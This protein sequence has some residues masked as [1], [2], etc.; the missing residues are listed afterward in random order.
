MAAFTLDEIITATGG[1]LLQG[2][3]EGSVSGI[4][5][6]SRKIQPGELFVAIQG[7]NFDGHDFI[8]AAVAAGAGAVLASKPVTVASEVAAVRVAD[9]L[10]A[11]GAIA[12]W[13]RRRFSIPVI[14]IT[15]SNGKTTTKDLVASVLAQ[16]YPVIKTEG[17]FNNEIGLP[18]TLL[19]FNIDFRAAVVEMGM[20][21][22]GQIRRLAGIAEPNIAIVTNVGLTHLELL[23]T[24]ENIARAKAELIESLPDD[25]LAVL[26]GDDPLVRSMRDKFNGRTILYGIEGP[27]LDYRAADIKIRDNGSIF[28]IYARGEII[29]AQL[30][31]PG[32]HNVLNALASVA[33]GREL[34]VS[35]DAIRKGLAAPDLTGK[36]LN[37][38][39]RNGL[40]IIDD[41]Y[42][43]SPTSARAALDV[44]AAT[45]EGRRKLAVLA[46]MLEL[47]PQA[48]AIHREIGEYAA[49]NGI[50]RLLAYGDLAREYV[51]GFNRISKGH[52][53]YF[54]AKLSLI[55]ELRSVIQ[56]GDVLLVKGSRG[57]KMEDIVAAISKLEVESSWN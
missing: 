28:K 14:G 4:A 50:D 12:R 21:G 43:A 44:L 6:D 18:L 24:Q 41:T 1:S 31:V 5:I 52:G 23:G 17:N 32:R 34:G 15:G 22:L 26:N 39:R 55:A 49:R 56:P 13:H 27:G 29:E 7:E 51:E 20:R 37:I 35:G 38:I 16:Q 57:M 33:V 3:K 25:G 53:E 40:I 8:A 46:D 45:G 48:P 54:S 19:R 30:P 36:R 47:G 9:T 2:D 10:E 11:L 42:N